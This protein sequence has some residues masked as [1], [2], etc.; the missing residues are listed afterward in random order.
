M[1]SNLLRPVF[2]MINPELTYT[3]P[4]WQT[5]AGLVDIMAHIFERYITKSKD[6]VLTDR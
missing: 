3:L 4:M 5:A 2:S 1:G 6:V